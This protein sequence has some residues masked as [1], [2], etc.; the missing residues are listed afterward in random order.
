MDAIIN[1]YLL[2]LGEFSFTMFDNTPNKHIAWIFFLLGSFLILLVFMNMLIAIMGSSF[3]N[4]YENQE[5][6]A[7][8]EQL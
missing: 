2:S 7:L 4:V 6:N 1:M 3:S 5:E 8:F